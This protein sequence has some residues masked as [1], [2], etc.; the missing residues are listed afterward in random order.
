MKVTFKK[1]RYYRG[2]LR[3]IGDVV[4]MD[5][6]H[7]RAFIRVNAAVPTIT[8]QAEKLLEES[9]PEESKFTQLTIDNVPFSSDTKV[10]LVT[11][12]GG[13]P[14]EP[15]LSKIMTRVKPNSDNGTKLENLSYRELQELCKEREV[16]ANGAKEELIQRLK[17][18]E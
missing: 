13:P 18:G 4:D 9:K 16:P 11:K 17:A 7:A 15:E 10:E 14:E 12:S 1:R 5:R 3:Q 6:K 8:L 2:I